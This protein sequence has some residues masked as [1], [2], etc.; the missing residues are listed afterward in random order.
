MPD[1]SS[2]VNPHRYHSSRRS[3]L[4]EADVITIK[5]RLASGQPAKQLAA[6]F[7]VSESAIC[8]IRKGRNWGWVHPC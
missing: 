8:D 1:G 3:K 7:R 6:E 2:R 5:R 4:V